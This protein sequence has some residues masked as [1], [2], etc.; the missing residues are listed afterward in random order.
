[1]SV[2]ISC[3]AAAFWLADKLFLD[4]AVAPLSIWLDVLVSQAFGFLL[5]VEG[6]N[7]C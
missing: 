3:S 2:N 5:I 1:M 4:S 7:D 6:V